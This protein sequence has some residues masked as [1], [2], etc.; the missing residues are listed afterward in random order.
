MRYT[1]NLRNTKAVESSDVNDEQKH[2]DY[3]IFSASMLDSQFGF[4]WTLCSMCV[5]TCVNIKFFWECVCVGGGS[6]RRERT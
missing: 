4:R 6:M 3:N 1:P 2:S 5:F